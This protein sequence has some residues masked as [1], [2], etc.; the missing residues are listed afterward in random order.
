M[1][2]APWNNAATAHQPKDLGVSQSR[3]TLLESGH[4]LSN[5]ASEGS[6]F[7][8]CKLLPLHPQRSLDFVQ[9]NALSLWHKKGTIVTWLVIE[10]HSDS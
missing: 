10:R 3:A 9:I 6:R 2:V 5:L 7:F 1:D 4:G 8:K